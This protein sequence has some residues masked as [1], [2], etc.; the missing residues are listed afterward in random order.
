MC[1]FPCVL[2]PA[3]S[4]RNAGSGNTK[5]NNLLR[6]HATVLYVGTLIEYTYILLLYYISLKYIN[7]SPV[8]LKTY[9]NIFCDKYLPTF[10]PF[11]SLTPDIV[12]GNL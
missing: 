3:P 12:R 1:P 9:N 10:H 2:G 5:N 6:R 7:N 11:V 8:Q 4:P